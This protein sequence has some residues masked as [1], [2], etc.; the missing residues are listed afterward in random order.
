RPR[1]PTLF[2]YTTLFRSGSAGILAGEVSATVTRRQGCRRSRFFSSV[3]SE[4]GDFVLLESGVGSAV[5]QLFVHGAGKVFIHL[6]LT[7]LR[8]EEHTSELQSRVDLV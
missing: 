6:E 1:A 7:G 4:V 8:S 2:P 5:N 3:T